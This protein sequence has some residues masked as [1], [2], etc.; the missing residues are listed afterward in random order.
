M[1][2]TNVMS[3]SWAPRFFL[4]QFSFTL[5]VS[6]KHNFTVIVLKMNRTR[7]HLVDFKVNNRLTLNYCSITREEIFLISVTLKVLIA[8]CVLYSA[9]PSVTHLLRAPKQGEG[10]GKALFLTLIAVGPFIL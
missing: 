9:D 2:N 5:E 7:V 8:M 6:I 10:M 4:K 3:M 1:V